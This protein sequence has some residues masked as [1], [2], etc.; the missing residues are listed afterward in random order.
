MQEPSPSLSPAR[1]HLLAASAS[2]MRRAPS[3]PEAK[4]FSALRG[5]RLGV[6]VRRQAVLGPFVVDMLVPAARLVIEVDGP[7]HA[8]QRSADARRD[9]ALARLG[10]RVLRMSAAQVCDSLDAAVERVRRALGQ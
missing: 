9:R 5:G 8:H 6:R 10:Y 4:L 2:C 1:R 3:W 7:H